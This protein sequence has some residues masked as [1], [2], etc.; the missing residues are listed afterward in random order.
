MA[1]SLR[2]NIER[3][4]SYGE[5][6][7]KSLRLDKLEQEELQLR[8]LINSLVGEDNFAAHPVTGIVYSKIILK[9]NLTKLVEEIKLLIQELGDRK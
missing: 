7:K 6:M 3:Q 1:K 5:H 2:T 4:L 9:N 8:A